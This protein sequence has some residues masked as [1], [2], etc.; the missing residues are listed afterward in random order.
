MSGSL[1]S[2]VAA[3]QP[4]E[5]AI[6]VEDL[7]AGY[8]QGPPG[9]RSTRF[10]VKGLNFDL[11]SGSIVALVGPNGS[12]K[13]TI[14][15]AIVDPHFRSTGRVT[16]GGSPL[17]PG[18]IAYMPQNSGST[19]FPWWNGT[20]NTSL[21]REIHGSDD[22]EAPKTTAARYG[23]T[24][25]L[26]RRV[27]ELSGGER[28]QVALLR[29]LRVPARKLFVLDEPF[30]G[31][32]AATRGLIVALLR[33]IAKEG[34]PVLLT[35]H[36][37][38]DIEALGARAYA[39]GGEPIE[40]LQELPVPRHSSAGPSAATEPVARQSSPVVAERQ[41][42]RQPAWT[43]AGI[44]F[45]V[46]AWAL[47]SATT[48]RPLL[49][50]GPAAVL[51]EVLRLFEDGSLVAD[52]GATATRALVAW[53]AGLAVALPLG[54]YLGYHRAV[55]NLISPW[56]SLARGFPVFTLTG[57]A[58]GLFVGAPETQRVFLIG[59]TVFF[60]AIQ[61]VASASFTAP[62]R[63]VELS[64][65]FGAGELFCLTRVMVFEAIGGVLAALETTLP[66]AFVVALVIESFLIPPVGVGRFVL[67]S[68]Q[69]ASVATTIAAVLWP[70]MLAAVGVALIRRA[71]RRWQFEL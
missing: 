62:R 49:V 27:T 25:P 18:D 41:P 16:L 45:G 26:N 36:R 8:Q 33:R 57:L 47:I 70:A 11:P 60:I 21:W 28:V 42:Q 5:Q 1:S 54:T 51:R 9:W 32:D 38:D 46:V 12:G 24:A 4:T 55:Y 20:R 61:I 37:T 2:R 58:I 64:R 68:L 59:L 53:C 35:S 10:V 66:L 3:P 23:L 34:T 44:V 50:P 52:V 43:A 7:H 17:R 22:T 67:N 56:L 63:R 6:S 40:K 13:S 71:A 69:G 48:D 29:A 39:I 30:E 14:L 15:R 19:L 65:I 31:L